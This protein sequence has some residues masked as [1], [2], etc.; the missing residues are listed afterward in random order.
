MSRKEWYVENRKLFHYHQLGFRKWKEINE[1]IAHVISTVLLPYNNNQTVIAVLLDVKATYHSVN[2][3]LLY[4]KLANTGF[5]INV[6]NLPFRMVDGRQIFISDNT[7]YF[8]GPR[9][10]SKGLPQGSPLNLILFNIY[11]TS[12]GITRNDTILISYADDIILLYR[13]VNIH[14]M[15]E[16]VNDELGI[17]I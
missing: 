13:G 17:Q 6:T 3:F 5:D 8:Y 7:N 16:Y 9:T 1:S 14:K 12:F 10:T 15:T 4:E 2:I 11:T